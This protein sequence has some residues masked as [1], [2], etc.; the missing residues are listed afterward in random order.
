MAFQSTS[1]E[2][3]NINANGLVKLRSGDIYMKDISSGVIMKSPDGQCWRMTVT[4]AGQ[5]EFK[6]INWP[7]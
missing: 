1:N 7:N 5:P 2:K 4:N 3:V 6:S